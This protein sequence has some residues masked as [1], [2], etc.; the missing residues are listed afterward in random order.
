MKMI[1]ILIL[2]VKRTMTRGDF[3]KYTKEEDMKNFEI[4]VL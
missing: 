1:H 3:S 4:S 2:K